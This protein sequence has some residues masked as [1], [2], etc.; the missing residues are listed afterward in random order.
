M[1]RRSVGLFLV[2]GAAIIL[3]ACSGSASFSIGGQPLHEAAEELI[4]GDLADQLGLGVLT[5]TCN[6]VDDPAVGTTFTCTATTSDGQVVEFD[7]VVD[8]EDHINI[9]STNVVSGPVIEQALYQALNE[10]NP[11]AG[12]LPD[13]VDC[14][15]EKVVLVAQK[16]TCE[17]NPAVGEAGTATL[18]LTDIDSGEFDYT[19]T[20]SSPAEA[21][22]TTT[23]ATATEV[24]PET[25]AE[26]VVLQFSDFGVGWEEGPQTPT[27]VD[28][29]IIEDCEYVG[30]LVEADGFLVEVDS[31]EFTMGDITVEHSVRV[32]ADTQTATD[33]VLLWAEQTT[34][35]CVVLGAEQAAG[36]AIESG[37]LAPFDEVEFSLQA[38]EDHIGEPRLTNLEL[39]NTLIAPDQQLVV[40][41]DQYFIQVGRIASRVGVLS[42]DTPWEGTQAVLELVVERMTAATE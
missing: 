18:N 11:A 36:A 42:P 2:L 9:E 25:I 22:T 38:F 21:T 41:N 5:P 17:V 8:R 29:R 19:F 6:E 28:Y 34:V 14:G 27:T 40:I 13:G 1:T 10:D 16:M 30:D 39:T 3:T 32:Y 20:P 15:G 24:S 7:G 35:D 26:A 23:E 31:P 12:L 37:E 4:A 33:I